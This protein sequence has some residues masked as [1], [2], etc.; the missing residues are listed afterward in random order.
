M[1]S[2]V[3]LTLAICPK[4]YSLSTIHKDFVY[5]FAKCRMIVVLNQFGIYKIYGSKSHKGYNILKQDKETPIKKIIVLPS[6]YSYITDKFVSHQSDIIVME[7]YDVTYLICDVPRILE[8]N[9]KYDKHPIDAIL[10]R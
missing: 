7:K 5:I 4:G 2:D 9:P 1:S 8:Y 10:Y 3:A 6:H